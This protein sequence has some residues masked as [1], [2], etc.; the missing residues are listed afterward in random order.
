MNSK[1][2]LD[3][4]RPLIGVPEDNTRFN[5]LLTK[6]YGTRTTSVDIGNCI[7]YCEK[8]FKFFSIFRPT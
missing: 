3:C 7:F 8:C 2:C 6:I 5:E 1:R 4:K